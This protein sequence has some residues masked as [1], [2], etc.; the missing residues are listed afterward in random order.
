MMK[1]SFFALCAF[2]IGLSLP[3][4]DGKSAHIFQMGT[5][6]YAQASCSTC[7]TCIPKDH[8]D[9]QQHF[10]TEIYET[11]R[12]LILDMVNGYI[13]PGLMSMT[14]E[15]TVT[16]LNQ[17]N[18]IGGFFDGWME[19]ETHNTLQQMQFENY[20]D[21]YPSEGVC[22][23][24]TNVR[25]LARTER[26]VKE[27]Q[28]IL[29]NRAMMRHLGR[30]NDNA[31]TGVKT[32]LGENFRASGAT[33]LQT[34]RSGRLKQFQDTYCNP[35]D[36][37]NYFQYLCEPEGLSPP[38]RE[39]MD[40]D[41]SY[42]Q[43]FAAQDTF[44]LDFIETLKNPFNP[45][46]SL[47]A[48]YAETLEDLIAL[49]KNLYGHS[50][51]IRPESQAFNVPEGYLNN[52]KLYPNIISPY[53]DYRSY[54]AKRNVVENSFNAIAAMKTMGSE[55]V[56][57]YMVTILTELGMPQES[58]Q[59]M[60]RSKPSY[61]AQMDILT[62]K[63]YQNPQFYVNLYEDPSNVKRKQ[64][65]LQAI[66]LMQD[67]DMFESKLRTEMMASILLELRLIRE[68]QAVQGSTE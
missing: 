63:I 44:D 55:A 9:T 13:I 46:Q 42:V 37:N 5:P 24:A 15:F 28:L 12:W 1:R 56:R 59:E 64:V 43:F 18:A 35:H 39:R 26:F 52:P 14:E 57:P 11:E 41:L 3:N 50:V 62:K 58:I 32:D 36:N 60:L 34:Y 25:S 48:N 66:G 19:N 29:S 21:F 10:T 53:L 2:Y 61:Y 31:A 16:A 67:W 7:D 38:D 27:N 45:T 54:I 8:A 51:A 40:K 47:P 22:V 6:A 30:E 68:H 4:I 20:Q 17:M 23:M 49:Q 33:G 65:A